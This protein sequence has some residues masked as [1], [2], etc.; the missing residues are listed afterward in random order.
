MRVSSTSTPAFDEPVL[1]LGLQLVGDL[2]R[3]SAQRLVSLDVGVVGIL[4]REIAHCRFGLHLDVVLVVLDLERG[5][6]GL[7]H[8]PDDDGGD[9]DRIALVVVHLDLL[10]LEVADAQ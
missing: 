2:V 5:F 1:H 9:F 3:V 8:T 7:D 6:G 10:T 4:R